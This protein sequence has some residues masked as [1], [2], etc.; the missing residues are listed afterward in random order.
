[1]PK[2]EFGTIGIR[3]IMALRLKELRTDKKLSQQK[4]ADDAGISRVS[5]GYHE[6]GDIS[7]TA[8]ELESYCRSLGCTPNELLGWMAEP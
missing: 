1:M 2:A 5:V 3:D 8:R 4:L 6:R 7:P